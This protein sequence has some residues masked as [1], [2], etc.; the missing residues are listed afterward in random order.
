[1]PSSARCHCW[2]HSA[3]P[4]RNSD[5]ASECELNRWKGRRV[6]RLIL[7]ALV[8]VSSRERRD[9]SRAINAAEL[10]LPTDSRVAEVR[11]ISFRPLDFTDGVSEPDVFPPTSGLWMSFILQPWHILRAALCG[12]A[13]LPKNTFHSRPSR[14]NPCGNRKMASCLNA[15][16]RRTH[17]VNQDYHQ[18]VGAVSNRTPRW[19]QAQLV[20]SLGSGNGFSG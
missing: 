19:A 1:M 20:L 11:F 10:E 9:V 15:R 5:V 8:T 13:F 14:R 18:A 2:E 3:W 17:L 7:G 6:V 12:W 16:F 4:G